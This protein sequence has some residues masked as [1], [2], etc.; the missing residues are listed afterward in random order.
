MGSGV[1]DLGAGAVCKVGGQGG[2]GGM[3]DGLGVGNAIA[4]AA[5]ALRSWVS[6]GV[7]SGIVGGY[8]TASGAEI[9]VRD[10]LLLLLLV[11]VHFELNRLMAPLTK[12]S[13]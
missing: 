13:K 1:V 6:L 4:I 2:L 3:R 10:G 12:R 7:S 8:V 11:R 5:E 9:A